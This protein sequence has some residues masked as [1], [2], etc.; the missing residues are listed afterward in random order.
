MTLMMLVLVVVTFAVSFPAW[1]VARRQGNDSPWMLGLALPALLVWVALTASGYG[2]Q[3]L[4]NIVEVFYL[5]AGGIALSWAH[6]LLVRH[7]GARPGPTA[8]WMIAGLVVM[9]ILL[10]T[11][12]PVLPE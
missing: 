7:T 4:S 9:A 11:F 2:A 12:M 1:Q 8:L 10:R 6:L 5:F 3:S